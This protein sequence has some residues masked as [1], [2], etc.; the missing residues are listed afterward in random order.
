VRKIEKGVERP[1]NAVG[2]GER[3]RKAK[4][5]ELTSEQRGDGDLPKIK[6]QAR[7]SGGGTKG[8]G[9]GEE[10]KRRGT[11]KKASRRNS[12]LDRPH[13]EIKVD[14]KNIRVKKGRDLDISSS[15]RSSSQG[16]GKIPSLASSEV[17][18]PRFCAEISNG[19]CG[20]RVAPKKGEGK[21]GGMGIIVASDGTAG[22]GEGVF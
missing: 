11:K 18:C 20:D 15:K 1:K 14:N 19:C 8:G 22:K 5:Y 10:I 2:V 6:D 3:G 7:R 12:I 9:G 4:S 16:G 17:T 13:N 21:R